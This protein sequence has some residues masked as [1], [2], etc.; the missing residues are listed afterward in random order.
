[1]KFVIHSLDGG[2]GLP[3]GFAPLIANGAGVDA[4]RT[5]ATQRKDVWKELDTTV[6][7]VAKK[8]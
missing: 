7:S 3:S 2:S 8:R 4:L 6:V 1:M 5:N